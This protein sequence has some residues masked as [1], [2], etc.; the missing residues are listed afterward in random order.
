MLLSSLWA[1]FF[2]AVL[3]VSGVKLHTPLFAFE[4]QR[5]MNNLSCVMRGTD[6]GPIAIDPR[7]LLCLRKSYVDTLLAHQTHV[8]RQ[9]NILMI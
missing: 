1:Y 7:Q 2:N 9:V 8:S 3:L 5:Q 4:W 6:G